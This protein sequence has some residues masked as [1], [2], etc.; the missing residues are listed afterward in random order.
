MC[1]KANAAHGC[2]FY[3][4]HH[5]GIGEDKAGEQ[6][7]SFSTPWAIDSLNPEDNAV[8]G[9]LALVSAVF[10]KLAPAGGAAAGPYTYDLQ[11]DTEQF[12]G[13]FNFG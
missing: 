11:V 5:P 6:G 3:A 7:M 2:F 1:L 13:I 9:G 12:R 8:K 10:V 4:R